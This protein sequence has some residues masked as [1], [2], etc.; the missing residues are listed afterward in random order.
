[1]KKI[2]FLLFVVAIALTMSC[3]HYV[4]VDDTAEIGFA[5]PEVTVTCNSA[6]IIIKPL[7]PSTTYYVR[8]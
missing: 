1:M 8:L 7:D 3:Y 6:E 5:E 4:D 2:P